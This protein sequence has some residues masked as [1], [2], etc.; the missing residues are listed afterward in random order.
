ML[1]SPYLLFLF[2]SNLRDGHHWSCRCRKE[3][4]YLTWKWWIA[5][6]C[7]FMDCSKCITDYYFKGTKREK[8][9]FLLKT[10]WIKKETQYLKRWRL[11]QH[12]WPPVH[13]GC[14]LLN[15]VWLRT[16]NLFLRD[17]FLSPPE[18]AMWVNK[19]AERKL[20]MIKRFC[21]VYVQTYISGRFKKDTL[22]HYLF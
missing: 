18:V 6:A 13:H 16:W 10:S 11:P 19:L 3:L 9:F 22:S 5:A 20:S 7:W 21:F 1:M 12:M 17:F 15:L 4:Y 8:L 14:D 2:F